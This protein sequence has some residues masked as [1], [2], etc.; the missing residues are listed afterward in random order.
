M[1]VGDLVICKFFKKYGIIIEEPRYMFEGYQGGTS[2]KALKK[3][4]Q[5]TWVLWDN[6]FKSKWKTDYLEVIGDDR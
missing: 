4:I 1:E 5:Y 2:L 6:G 3:E